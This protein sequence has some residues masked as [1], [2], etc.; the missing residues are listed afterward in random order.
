V[1]VGLFLPAA[2]V[3]NLE[4]VLLPTVTWANARQVRAFYG[5]TDAES[6]ANGFAA[7]APGAGWENAAFEIGADWSAGGG[8]HFIASFAYQRLLGEAAGSPI[9]QTRNQS[10]ALGGIAWR[11]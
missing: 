6:A 1:N 10:S 9:V 4:L 11:F 3:S 5:V 8:L 2:P 7:Y